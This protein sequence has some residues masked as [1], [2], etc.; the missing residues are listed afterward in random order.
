[1]TEDLE[2]FSVYGFSV[3]YPKDSWVEFNPKSRRPQGDV[4][5]HFED[6]TRIFLSW[7][8][9]QRALKSFQSVEQHAEHTL[10]TI[11]KS[12]NVRNFERVTQDTI[13]IHTHRGAFNRIRLEEMRAGL[14]TSRK[15]VQQDAYSVH[16]HC[17]ESSR[18]FVIY[19]VVAK[20][21]ENEYGPILT[22]MAN[23]LE[24]H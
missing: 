22:T 16:V 18:Y 20:S 13:T 8:D 12:V 9:L 5:F 10:N 21:A 15:G 19:T 17:P 2:R 6:R 4:V 7:G 24:C 23:S 11:R 3:N 1:M 14:L